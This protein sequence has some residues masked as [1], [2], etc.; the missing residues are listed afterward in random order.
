MSLRWQSEENG[1]STAVH[2]PPLLGSCKSTLIGK[3]AMERLSQYGLD[4]Q[5]HDDNASANIERANEAKP[6]EVFRDMRQFAERL[7][8]I[9]TGGRRQA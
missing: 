5:T 7:Y 2:P 9:G 3:Q 6:L 4:W 1:V 8:N